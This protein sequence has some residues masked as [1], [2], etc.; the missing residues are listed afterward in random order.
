MNLYINEIDEYDEYLKKIIEYLP[1]Y[2]DTLKI[3]DYLPLVVEKLS[4]FT[5]AIIKANNGEI[6]STLKYIYQELDKAIYYLYRS[7]YLI[8]INK[9]ENKVNLTNKPLDSILSEL[10]KELMEDTKYLNNEH[11]E[12]EFLN[13]ISDEA[14]FLLGMKKT[15]ETNDGD[16]DTQCAEE[17]LFLKR[18][19]YMK[20][21]ESKYCNEIEVEKNRELIECYKNRKIKNIKD[22]ILNNKPLPHENNM[23][24]EERLEYLKN[25]KL[26]IEDEIHKVEEMI[27]SG[28]EVESFSAENEI[29][30]EYLKYIDKLKKESEILRDATNKYMGQMMIPYMKEGKNIK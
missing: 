4:E 28:E 16:D 29:K 18:F 6:G 19:L 7:N 20:L 27:K 5:I 9:E 1:I 10:L 15:Y 22:K 26:N 21:L 17:S 12:I 25:V 3:V 13:N 11:N 2:L 24:L 23:G 30:E 8:P 14:L